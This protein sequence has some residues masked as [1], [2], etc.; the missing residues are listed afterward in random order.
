MMERTR[1]VSPRNGSLVK[2]ADETATSGEP[3]QLIDEDAPLPPVLAGSENDP[4]EAEHVDDVEDMVHLLD[5]VWPRGDCDRER[6]PRKFGRFSI[7]G[8]LGRGGFGVVYLAEDP[9][10]L[11][12]V[13]LNLPRIGVLSGAECWR[14]FLREAQ[15]ASRLNHPNVIPLLEAGELGPVGFIVSAYV[16]GPSL[17]QWLRHDRAA[18]S[19]RWGAQVVA[20]LARAMEHAHAR[21]IL[22]RDLKPANVMLDAPECDGDFSKR[23]AWEGRDPTK[24]LPRICDFGMA[25]LREAEG[26][27]TRSRIACGSPPYMAPEQAEGRQNEIGPKTDVYGLGAILYEILTG[28]PPFLGKSD[29]EILRYVVAEEPVAPHKLRPGIPR[30]LETICLKCLSKRTEHRYASALAL[31]A[32]L[33]SY[34]DGRPINAR[35]AA[36]WTR[37]W[38]WAR[39]HPSSAALA[40]AIGMAIVAGLGG[41]LW[42]HSVLQSANQRISGINDRLTD[43]NEQLRKAL[44]EKDATARELRRQMAVRQVFGAQRAV[45][46]KNFE[47]AQRLLED[48]EPELG[49]PPNP[50]FAW[51]Y[52]RKF[53]QER[54][55][56]L[57]G[58]GETIFGLAASPDGNTLA[59]SDGRGEVRVWDLATGRCRFTG[60]RPSGSHRQLVFSPDGKSLTASDFAIRPI[61]IWDL[62]S[63]QL[64]GIQN[65]GVPRPGNRLLFF[66]AEADALYLHAIRVP[67]EPGLAPASAWTITPAGVIPAP[68]G[69]ASRSGPD[70]GAVPRLRAITKLLDGHVLPPASMNALRPHAAMEL[71]QPGIAAT[72]DGALTAIDRGDGTFLVFQPDTGV[73]VAAGRVGQKGIAIV[74]FHPEPNG[75]KPVPGER[76]RLERLAHALVPNP[77]APGQGP[78][79]IIEATHREPAAFRADG[80]Q[81]AIWH[82]LEKR[83]VAID[84]ESG[85]EQA[86]LH[87][88]EF[89]NVNVAT[90][91]GN[92]E[93]V[94][95]GSTNGVVRIWRLRPTLAPTVLRGHR[96][97]EAWAVA[98]SNDGRT[99]ASGGDDHEVRLWDVATGEET[100]ILSGH[101]SLVTSLAFT[102]DDR[103]LVSGSFDRTKPVILWDLATKRPSLLPDLPKDRVRAVSL[104][105]DGRILAAGSDDRTLKLWNLEQGC[106][107][108][109]IAEHT[110]GI[111]GVDFSP[112]GRVVVSAG[113]L[114]RIVFTDT[115]TGVSR[116][117]ETANDP[118]AAVFST[119]GLRLF[120][121]DS[122]GVIT[123]WDVAGG[124]KIASLPGHESEVNSLAISPDGETLAS[125]GEDR[126]V[127]LWDTRTR[128]E[129]LCLTD[130]K[131]QVN[132]VAFSP[133]GTILAAADHSG[134][135]TLW[136]CRP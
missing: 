57:R 133:D 14:R 98:F 94:A 29:L 100:D 27:E 55:E 105:R 136:R 70:A 135:I 84:L 106:L 43:A 126:T 2:L 134:A 1:D 96:P 50:S 40:A 37:G 92:E 124:I 86:A 36:I 114:R 80:R 95:L 107:V 110:A 65:S 49:S 74:L 88:G 31:A 121:A 5:K 87:L 131:A 75:A 24:W 68:M 120:S 101:E 33:Q 41:L 103:T 56:V 12:K 71:V 85:H 99:L 129:L 122:G 32:D 20:A 63:G 10:R 19:P 7:L 116:P 82:E 42:H 119:D 78:D 47:L 52:L 79:M 61:V 104:S 48:A 109:T 108:H 58:H 34:L 69:V 62:P 53:I 9:L 30:D 112:D 16:A 132:S 113:G 117:A 73:V 39:R 72:R 76:D 59:S 93:A 3:G 46:E 38:K 51:L 18:A 26:D 28:R 127:R 22:H 67:P 66:R 21:G 90:Y 6:T 118:G 91:L 25:K 83:V 77:S 125:A 23:L 81:L 54:V 44:E 64:H 89:G 35:P 11:R 115:K 8:E 13:A 15:A 111:S 97:A 17:D 123:I 60:A 45:A 130:C 102:P 4:I 128:Q